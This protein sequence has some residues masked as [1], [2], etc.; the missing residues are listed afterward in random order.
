MSLEVTGQQ[1]SAAGGHRKEQTMRTTISRLITFI[2]ALCG[3]GLLAL[4]TVPAATA[5]PAPP[6]SADEVDDLVDAYERHQTFRGV[7]NHNLPATPAGGFNLGEVSISAPSG[8]TGVAGDGYVDY[9]QIGEH[10]SLVAASDGPGMDRFGV[11]IAEGG[12][13]NYRFPADVPAGAT[14]VHTDAGT[15]EITT[16][17]GK[18]TT[19]APALAVDATGR[20][21][22][23]GY[24]LTDG[25]LDVN[26]NLEGAA[27]PV[28]V[29]PVSAYYW[30]GHQRWYS[31]SDVQRYASWWGA[32]SVIKLP[33]KTLR[34]PAKWLCDRTVGRYINWVLGKFE[35]AKRHGRC[36]WFK[37]AKTGQIWSIGTY[38]CDWP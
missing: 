17:E 15:I 5:E 18:T 24:T 30:W 4:P 32:A 28:I 7:A 2:L 12:S 11:V 1:Q 27:F 16:V 25:F 8:G 33:C 34:G 26:V 19:L 31:I 38:R 20:V 6:P 23:A 29:D 35:H 37:Q 36:L 9:G 10:A 3:L 22:P 14:V 21:L 13:D